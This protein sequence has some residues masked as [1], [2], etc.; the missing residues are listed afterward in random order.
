MLRGVNQSSFPV[1]GTRFIDILRLQSLRVV[2][3]A[4]GDMVPALAVLAR[5]QRLAGI[6]DRRAARR[7]ADFVP[8]FR[9][10]HNDSRARALRVRIVRFTY[11][12]YPRSSDRG[13]IEAPSPFSPR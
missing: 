3:G 2:K 9:H 8:A 4:S 11:E 10:Q 1:T 12:L 6:R 5:D 13:P 7:F